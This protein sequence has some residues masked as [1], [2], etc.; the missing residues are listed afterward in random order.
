MA[1]YCTSVRPYFHEPQASE[2]TAQECNIQ[3]YYLLNHQII[4]YHSDLENRQL[5]CMRGSKVVAA[6]I[7]N[8]LQAV[9]C[10]YT[11]KYPQVCNRMWAS[12]S[13]YRPVYV[14][15]QTRK[16]T[17]CVQVVYTVLCSTDT[18]QVWYRSVTRVCNRCVIIRAVYRLYLRVCT[19]M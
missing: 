9:A 12:T 17:C 18:T 16:S 19:E 2:N 8:E 11:A 3:P 1:G 4:I 13:C 6:C 15:L 14:A 5:L 10:C 7:F